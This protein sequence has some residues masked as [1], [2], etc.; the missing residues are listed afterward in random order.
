MDAGGGG[1][2]LLMG[3]NRKAATLVIGGSCKEATL[4]STFAG[5]P[6]R[7]CVARP[8]AVGKAFEVRWY[9]GAGARFL[10]RAS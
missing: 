7:N 9:G 1:A 2:K 5:G 6:E 10:R 3:G 4:D 8:M